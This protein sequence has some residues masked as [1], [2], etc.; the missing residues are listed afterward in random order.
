MLLVH[1]VASY[2]RSR[3]TVPRRSLPVPDAAAVLVAA[4]HLFYTHCIRF[5][6][7]ALVAVKLETEIA[8][9]VSLANESLDFVFGYS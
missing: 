9:H 3:R 6:G 5:V 2:Q 8:C 4:D 7:L 1:A